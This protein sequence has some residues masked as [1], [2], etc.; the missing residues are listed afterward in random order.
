MC[1][2][3]DFQPFNCPIWPRFLFEYRS[4]INSVNNHR[5]A[6]SI[7]R[8]LLTLLK[9]LLAG[10]IGG[11]ANSSQHRKKH[12]WVSRSCFLVGFNSCESVHCNHCFIA[13][14]KQWLR[15]TLCE[16]GPLISTPRYIY[17]PWLLLSL[18]LI[19]M[20]AQ[21]WRRSYC[22]TEVHVNAFPDCN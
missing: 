21:H 16:L 22:Q 7:M 4:L 5:H 20:D 18:F 3:A 1:F 10:E 13:R 2:N 17:S 6:L 14:S 9:I 8:D 11:K 19:F 12:Q 15:N